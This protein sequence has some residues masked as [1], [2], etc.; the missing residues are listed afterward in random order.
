MGSVHDLKTPVMPTL[1]RLITFRDHVTGFGERVLSG[2]LEAGVL[3]SFLVFD[4]AARGPDVEVVQSRMG[5]ALGREMRLMGRVSSA[6][7]T[8]LIVPPLKVV[9]LAWVLRSLAHAETI[10]Q[11]AGFLM[12]ISRLEIVGS[13]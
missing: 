7:R 2:N 4:E 13:S 11:P 3:I 8:A 12:T 6:R 10:G 5:V 9:T 1:A